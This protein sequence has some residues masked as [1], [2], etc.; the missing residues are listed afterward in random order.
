MV[1]AQENK[2]RIDSLTLEI[3][4]Q[5][6][7]E[8]AETLRLLGIEHYYNSH[9]TF[10]L[11]NALA[12]LE[13]FEEHNNDTSIAY[14]NLLLGGIYERSGDY[15]RAEIHNLKALSGARN[16]NHVNVESFALM[17]LAL[18]AGVRKDYEMC[19]Q[20]NN[21]SLKIAKSIKNYR[22]VI[23]IYSNLS[24]VYYKQK[25]HAKSIETIDSGLVALNNI[26]EEKKMKYDYISREIAL[27]LNLSDNYFALKKFNKLEVL[28]EEL[29]LLKERMTLRQTKELYRLFAALNKENNNYSKA[30]FYFELER[31]FIDSINVRE[32]NQA[33]I[34]VKIEN[35]I[36]YQ[37][38]ENQLLLKEKEVAELKITKQ[39]NKVSMLFLILL[40]SFTIMAVIFY[41]YITI[42]QK[43]IQL[44]QTNLE[45]LENQKTHPLKIELK[46][47]KT[48]S[49]NKVDISETQKQ[50]LVDKLNE[51]FN[52][53]VFKDDSLT[54]NS[55]AKQLDTNRNYLTIVIKELNPSGFLDFV[56]EYRIKK[57][58]EV[59]SDPNFFHLTIEHISQEVGFKSQP[60]FNKAFKKFTGV[61]PSFYLNEVKKKT[62]NA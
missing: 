47:I 22:S 37:E 13:I 4:H 18:I 24:S 48:P 12:A 51:A 7:V 49:P 19:Y 53:E 45:M 36:K 3:Q 41:Y 30:I 55:L 57:S 46:P 31:K 42:R 11:E 21:E 62:I 40:F 17:N 44:V 26:P 61:T 29:L 56:N 5:E 28:L 9:Y 6:G 10:A 59:L 20:Y 27:K 8:K 52:N 43:N 54:V 58:W 50:L 32:H 16:T 2:E 14:S 1:F 15:N 34:D 38:Q 33:L 35:E 60:T 23:R 25:M 39:E